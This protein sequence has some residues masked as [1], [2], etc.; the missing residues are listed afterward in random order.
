M[1]TDSVRQCGNGLPLKKSAMLVA[2]DPHLPHFA[3]GSRGPGCSRGTARYR[4]AEAKSGGMSWKRAA[5]GRASWT[6]VAG[7]GGAGE[8]M[9]SREEML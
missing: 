6:K 7:A 4:S 1:P 2:A 9:R 8:C 3:R 5:A